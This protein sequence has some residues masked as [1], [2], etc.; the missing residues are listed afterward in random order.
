MEWEGI[1]GRRKTKKSR[2]AVPVI[3]PLRQFLD[4][5]RLRS[6]NPSVTQ[7]CY[8]KTLPSQSLDAM[9]RLEKFV[10]ASTAVQ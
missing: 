1:A 3:R 2:A 10:V 5:R 4:A 7:Q 6:G 8:V 9:Q